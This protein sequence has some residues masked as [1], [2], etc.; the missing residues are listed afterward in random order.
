M[1]YAHG[2]N[3]NRGCALLCDCDI[4]ACKRRHGNRPFSDRGV[5]FDGKC[6]ALAPL[7][8]P[9]SGTAAAGRLRSGRF[10]PAGEVQAVELGET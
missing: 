6:V 5:L 3:P 9:A 1:S 4:V 10:S 8:K 7:P 2:T